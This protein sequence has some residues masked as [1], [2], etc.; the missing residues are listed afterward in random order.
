[1]GTWG[2]SLIVNKTL[3]ICRA[4][5]YFEL[6]NFLHPALPPQSKHARFA[7]QKRRGELGIKHLGGSG[8]RIN[9][10]AA[11]EDRTPGAGTH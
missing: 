6:L 3:G 10:E 5:N 9:E 4:R 2:L 7:A 8:L 11:K 1:M